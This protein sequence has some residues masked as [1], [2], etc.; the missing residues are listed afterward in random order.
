MWSDNYKRVLVDSCFED[1]KLAG[2]KKKERKLAGGE[3]AR[4]EPTPPW[5]DKSCTVEGESGVTLDMT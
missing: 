4:Q 5:D 1:R 3:E 2:K